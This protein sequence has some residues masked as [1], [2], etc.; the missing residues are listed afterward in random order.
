LKKLPSLAPIK[1]DLPP[2]SA[3]ALAAHEASFA[4]EDSDGCD[5]SGMSPVSPRCI[6]WKA[7]QEA[8]RTH[9]QLDAK[10]SPKRKTKE[11]LDA[12]FEEVYADMDED[13]HRQWLFEFHQH[14]ADEQLKQK[15]DQ[16]DY[17]RRHNVYYVDHILGADWNEVQGEGAG[18]DRS[19]LMAKV[20]VIRARVRARDNLL[21]RA[22]DSMADEDKVRLDEF[23]LLHANK[24]RG[25][26]DSDSEDDFGEDSGSDSD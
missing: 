24:C 6:E 7:R 9:L 1:T 15:R 25:D 14:W 12:E 2:L 16:R 19:P 22:R 11:E 3:A 20:E 8:K 4:N 21:V 23:L 5:V 10:L 18:R 17:A 13:I 26:D